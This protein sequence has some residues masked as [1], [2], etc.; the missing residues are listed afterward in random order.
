MADLQSCLD[1]EC[2]RMVA[3]AFTE[4]YV[5]AMKAFTEKRKGVFKGR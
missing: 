2:E 1:T 5:E 4:D 3:G